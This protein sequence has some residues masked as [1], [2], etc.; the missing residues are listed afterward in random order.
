MSRSNPL[1]H[2]CSHRCTGLLCELR[3][4]STSRP[5]VYQT[6]SSRQETERSQDASQ[7][8]PEPDS[9]PSES[10]DYPAHT[11][12]RLPVRTSAL[13]GRFAAGDLPVRS[14][15]FRALAGRPA[16][17]RHPARSRCSRPPADRAASGNRRPQTHAEC[18][19]CCQADRS[20]RHCSR[21]VSPHRRW[22]YR[23]TEAL[24]GPKRPSA[25]SDSA[26]SAQS[27]HKEAS[28]RENPR[29]MPPSPSSP[30]DPQTAYSVHRRVS[31]RFLPGHCQAARKRSP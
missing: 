19:R 25:T 24:S 21:K 7:R 3:R 20:F 13:T 11:C 2:L 30:Q 1:G 23:E 26:S 12:S 22:L 10:A 4:Y 27:L 9:P 17:D 15:C 5:S 28:R 29:R 8:S 31:A 6:E 16:A 18:R 14:R